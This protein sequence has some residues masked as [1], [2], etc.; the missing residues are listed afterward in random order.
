MQCS[1]ESS[2]N[3]SII[4]FLLEKIRVRAK[5]ESGVDSA[6]TILVRASEYHPPPSKNKTVAEAKG[7]S[8]FDLNRD[9][10]G[11]AP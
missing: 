5:S 6:G 11:D 9:N 4:N 1:L 10:H 3:P 8:M 2:I 7:F